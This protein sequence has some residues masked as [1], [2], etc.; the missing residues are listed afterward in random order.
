MVLAA[1]SLM[2]ANVQAD[3]PAGSTIALDD[4]VLLDGG[5]KTVDDLLLAI[6]V[7]VRVHDEHELIPVYPN[8]LLW[9]VRPQPGC[10]SRGEQSPCGVVNGC[11]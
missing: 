8:H 4:V 9:S 7:R 5:A 1:V 6:L 2:E 11:T 10:W 3:V